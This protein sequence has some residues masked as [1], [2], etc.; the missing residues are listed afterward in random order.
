MQ[1]WPNRQMPE[2]LINSYW[3]QLLCAVSHCHQSLV[4][5]HDL[6][7]EVISVSKAGHVKL[8][9]F[10]NALLLREV[11]DRDPDEIVGVWPYSAP[12]VLLRKRGSD[13]DATLSDVWGLGIILADMLIG[14][15][16]ITSRVSSR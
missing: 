3:V 15:G 6:R 12:E 5:H 7:P 13:Y 11:R 16:E 9:G 1:N 8:M 2:E 14:P 10:S 4:C